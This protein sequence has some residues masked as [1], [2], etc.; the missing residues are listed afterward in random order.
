MAIDPKLE[1]LLKQVYDG[2]REGLRKAEDPAAYKK[3][4][5]DF[6]FHMTDWM[7][8]LERLRELYQHPEKADPDEACTFIIGFL[9]HVIPHLNAAG[10][11]LLDE[12]PDAFAKPATPKKAK[13]RKR[14]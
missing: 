10:R 14:A 13:A 7:S 6:V 4:R 12:I 1:R 2:A 8:D 5:Y 3:L 9:Y 11:L